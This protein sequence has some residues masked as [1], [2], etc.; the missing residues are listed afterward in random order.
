MILEW[1]LEVEVE[2]SEWDAS[3]RSGLLMNVLEFELERLEHLRLRSSDYTDSQLKMLN[4]NVRGPDS[5]PSV[6]TA[7]AKMGV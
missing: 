7:T 1:N 2:A 4:G 6:G 5:S 3:D